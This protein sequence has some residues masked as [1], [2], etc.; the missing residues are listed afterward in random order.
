MK[1]LAATAP[2]TGAGT[3]SVSFFVPMPTATATPAALMTFFVASVFFSPVRMRAGRR[4]QSGSGTRASSWSMTW[5]VSWLTSWGSF[6]L[7][8]LLQPLLVHCPHLQLDQLMHLLLQR[9]FAFTIAM[10][11][12]VFLLGCSHQLREIG[13][14]LEAY[15]L[16][17]RALYYMLVEQ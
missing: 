9:Q 6:P 8:L 3:L 5:L 4:N 2:G 12:F 7:R 1:S 10:L 13:I 11:L 17:W 15:G 14:L 16:A